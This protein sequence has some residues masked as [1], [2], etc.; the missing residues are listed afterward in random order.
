MPQNN[1]PATSVEIRSDA[2]LVKMRIS[3]DED[4]EDFVRRMEYQHRVS[5][6]SVVETALLLL[7]SLGDEVIG[8]TLLNARASMRR[9]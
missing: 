7:M 8:A 6:S 4:V 3:V 9:R 1:V 2:R 5:K